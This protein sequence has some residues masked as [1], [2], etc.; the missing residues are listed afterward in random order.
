[1]NDMVSI[2]KIASAAGVA[3]KAFSRF[4]GSCSVGDSTAAAEPAPGDFFRGDN[5]LSLSASTSL[6]IDS[7]VRLD[8]FLARAAWG[9][10][11]NQIVLC[12]LIERHGKLKNN[13]L[14][15]GG[16]G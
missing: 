2:R 4:A 10:A 6:E 15:V 14:V 11:E 12:G 8:D 3:D 7:E 16:I 1:M 5:P 9:A 13:V